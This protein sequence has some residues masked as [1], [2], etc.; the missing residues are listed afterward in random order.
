MV[1]VPS[2]LR[3]RHPLQKGDPKWGG[4]RSITTT[5]SGEW[6]RV[7]VDHDGDHIV[8]SLNGATMIDVR[9]N[10]ISKAGGI[11]LWTKADARTSF[12]DLL[13][14]PENEQ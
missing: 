7:T 10:T 5:R 2:R 3:L 12:D 11:G 1:G 6:H 4:G 14:S 8:C 13:V 9:D